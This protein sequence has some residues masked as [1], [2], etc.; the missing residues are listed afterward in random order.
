MNALPFAVAAI[1][2][3]DGLVLAANE[4]WCRLHREC[5]ATDAEGAPGCRLGEIFPHAA[6]AATAALH[7]TGGAST[8]S[9]RNL[10][11]ACEAGDA[12]TWW[13]LDI[14][15][16]PEAPDTLLVT[17]REVTEDV[18]ARREA[19]MHLREGKQF[20][21][22]VLDALPT[23]VAVLDGRGTI[24]AANAAWDRFASESGAAPGAVSVGVDYLAVCRAGS[25]SG[26]GA[27]QE[28]LEGLEGVLAGRRGS[29]VLEYPCH[30]PERER[31][32]LMHA[33]RPAHG[34]AGAVV[35]HIEITGLKRAERAAADSA[36]RL[37]RVQRIGRVGGFEI[38]LRDGV[39]A[40]GRRR[41]AEYMS[42]HGAESCEAVEYY[43]DWLR[44]L[45]PQDRA[46][47]E[48]TF[49]DAVSNASA[50]LDYAQDYRIVTPGGETRWISAR[51]E[52]ERDPATGIARRM[53][54][55]H[56]DVTE[57]KQ[58]EEQARHSAG[59]LRAV[60]EATPDL[61]W[62]KDT[63]GRIT[64]AN[65][66]ALALLGGGDPAKV[67][68]LGARELIPDPEHAACVMENDARIM[69]AGR[70]ERV[71]EAFGALVFQTVK[72]PLRDT[73]GRIVGVVGV[74]RD[75]TEQ[76][77]AAAALRIAAEDNARLAAIV[78]CST[79]AII[80]FDA[81]DGR[82]RSWNA[83]AEALFGWTEAEAVGAPVTLLLPPD[84]ARDEPTGVFR[85]VMDGE[86]VHEH[87]TVRQTRNG[88]RIPVSI[89][90][91]RMVD[92]AG[93]VIGVS[94]IFRDLRARN[95]AEAA[96]ARSEARYRSFVEASSSIIWT[97]TPDGQVGEPV[98]AW[99]AY[100]GQSYEQARGLGFLDV[101]H[102]ADRPAVIAAWQAAVAHGESYSVEYRLR[103]HDGTWRHVAA[104]GAPVRDAGGG[105]VE[106]IGTCTDVTEQR[107]AD[108]ALRES[109]AR[110]RA[111]AEAHPGFVFE[112]DA[113]G[114]N[115]YIS[116]N[117]E[118]FTGLP[119]AA[120]L[121]DGWMQALHP[122][123][124]A[125]AAAT[126]G[127]AVRAGGPY[128][129]EYRFRAADGNTRWF[130]CRGNPLRN[131]EG[132]I[133][134]WFGAAVDITEIVHAREATARQAVEL[135]RR[136]AERTRA[137]SDAARELAAE[138]RQREETQAA[139]LQSQKLEALGQLTGGVAHDFNNVLAAVIGSYRLIRKQAT[140]DARLI[141]LVGHGERAAERAT[142]LIRQLM[143][144]ARK[145][146]LRPVLTDLAEIVRQAR[147]MVAHAA[148]PGVRCGFTVADAVWPVIVDP[149][150][151]ETVLLNLAANARDA[152]PRGGALTV[153]LRNAA[154]EEA[155]P[156]LP[157]G[158]DHVLLA[159]ADT[160]TGMDAE[161]LR[162]ATEPFFTTKAAGKGTGL[163]LAS[164]HGFAVQSGGTL[165][166]RSTP[167]EGT[168]VE[169]FLPRAAVL[170]GGDDA[171][172]PGSRTGLGGDALDESRHG[173]A[174]ILVVDD[175]DGV[176][177][178]TGEILRGLGYRVVEAPSAEA[179][180]ALA[181]AGGVE[182][183]MLVTDVVMGGASGPA[184]AARLRAEWPHLPVLYITGHAAGAALTGAPV[185]GKPFT[186][187]ALAG[188][189][190]Q[191]LGRL[192][193]RAASRVRRGAADRLRD[194]L[195]RPELRGTYL[196]WLALRGG[197][198]GALPSTSTFRIE[199][200]PEAVRDNAFLAEALGEDCAGGF[201]YEHV[202]R[203]LE[204]RLGRPLMGTV[205]EAE[206]DGLGEAM[207]GSLSAAYRRCVVTH[208]P[209]YD[210]V[211][212]SPGDGGPGLL[213][214]R[215]IVPLSA[216]GVAVTHVAGI[217]LLTEL[218]APDDAGP[219][220]TQGNRLA[221]R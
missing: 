158:R 203:A 132:A 165:R 4:A 114:H 42:I 97:M 125:R 123:D 17:A 105:L 73:E 211:R 210:Y 91:A 30:L 100:T 40:A 144:F 145:E 149:V 214:E 57:L 172:A 218:P 178:V 75:V 190:L 163:G 202:G 88:T 107:A 23:H 18:P 28:A 174:T 191:G 82:I 164:A 60:M 44:R 152:M 110:F 195:R 119:T 68:G 93:R 196:R 8:A 188:A 192:P 15:P 95:A 24:V 59:L 6:A 197:G 39:V 52:I 66:A 116:R 146:E 50:V 128:E 51:A 1:A 170:P 168:V 175:D 45:H 124:R 2:A 111:L 177:P 36:A 120:L 103:R 89:T 189:V 201:H 219:D 87:E 161:T 126:W 193:D 21:R 16:H 43:A 20:L 7:G 131:A 216:N 138:M 140:G 142:R 53:L 217:S 180:E 199:D 101:I 173:G 46:R 136:V 215:L 169:I 61:V 63:E 3:A 122:E 159:V 133:I 112:S 9:L 187:A 55:A 49:L 204:D 41:S 213:L 11:L 141:E 83:G 148:S 139:L 38:D 212:V 209:H 194:R 27:A 186:E 94:G 19:E 92:A 67:I 5:G 181:H 32:Y 151:L 200:L 118:D 184:L 77:Q 76:R 96:L 74:S 167:G 80:S 115:T 84:I 47:A 208:A 104:R 156:E 150:R 198:A 185:L 79:D 179:A 37:A 183:H 220:G 221:G 22:G 109:E 176:R 86:R 69:A 58:A 182:I 81:A 70:A 62:A 166:L 155:P 78:A 64:L 65:G 113:A 35:S 108:A 121:G 129:A 206:D 25:L 162:R 26:D 13:D 34:A 10:P 33:A 56:L 31:W 48:A 130:L 127:E 160:G 134:R 106:W 171:A 85:R 153:T 117:F 54:G 98:P 90:A 72:A 143:A 207:G 137:L 102:A 147:D 12:A 71:E 14:V 205:V 157:P 154:R 99:Q 29:F 135:E